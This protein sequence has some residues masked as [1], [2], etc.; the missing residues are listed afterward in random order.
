MLFGGREN[1]QILIKRGWLGLLFFRLNRAEACT[2][3]RLLGVI[4]FLFGDEL[5]SF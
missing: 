4:P 3:H 1:F 2:V 5:C